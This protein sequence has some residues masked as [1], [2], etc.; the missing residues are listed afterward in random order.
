MKVFLVNIHGERGGH[1]EDPKVGGGGEGRTRLAER[2]V[3]GWTREHSDNSPRPLPAPKCLEHKSE[4]PVA[5]LGK[6][7]RGLS[8]GRRQESKGVTCKRDNRD[9]NLPHY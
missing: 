3:G 6:Q 5:R 7:P 1:L 9:S 8:N 2:C 4:E